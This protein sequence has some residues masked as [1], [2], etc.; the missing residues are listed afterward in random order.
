MSKFKIDIKPPGATSR[1]Y[2]IHILHYLQIFMGAGIFIQNVWPFVD[3]MLPE[4]QN[5]LIK[6][7][8]NEIY[9][10]N[11]SKLLL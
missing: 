2:G 4:N 5:F 8:K 11:F 3:E 6:T 1:I 9:R 7:L 10:A